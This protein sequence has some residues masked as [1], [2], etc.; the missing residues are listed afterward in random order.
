M[1]NNS[2]MIL[3]LIS[4]IV[5][6]LAGICYL[7]F[8]KIKIELDKH[9]EILTM[10][11]EKIELLLNLNE[12]IMNNKDIQST[13]YN[14]DIPPPTENTLSQSEDIR[15]KLDNDDIQMMKTHIDNSIEVE[16]VK[17]DEVEEVKVDEVEEVEVDEV[18]EVDEVEEVEV[19]E[20]TVDEVE[21]EEVEVEVNKVDE[22]EVDEVEVNKVDDI[23]DNIEINN[24]QI[25]SETILNISDD[26]SIDNIMDNISDNDL[27]DIDIVHNNAKVEIYDEYIQKSVKELRDILSDKGLQL[28]GNK[29]KLVNRIIEN[30]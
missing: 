2:N 21:V 4:I 8:K 26:I 9:K 10:Y 30:M 11:K 28:S 27:E 24:I 15:T 5:V 25:D 3:L 7:E 19:E 20:V 1:T 14:Y 16:E 29:S 22:V 12:K 6:V 17:V 13:N 18:D 23:D